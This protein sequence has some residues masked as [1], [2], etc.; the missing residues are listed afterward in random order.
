MAMLLTLRV[1]RI[2]DGLPIQIKILEGRVVETE[3]LPLDPESLDGIPFIAP[4]LFDI[5][6]NGY[7]GKWFCDEHLTVDTVFDV[8]RLTGEQRCR[9]ILPNA[10]YV[11]R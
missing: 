10:H 5:Q 3:L 7:R 8:C 2:E 11:F 6:I 9:H 1:R 4:G